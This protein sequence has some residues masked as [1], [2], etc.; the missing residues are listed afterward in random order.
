MLAEREAWKMAE[1][2]DK[3]DLVV[4]NPSLVI[5]PG[6]NPN[7]TSESYSIFKQIG[8]GDFKFGAPDYRIGCVDVR[9]LAEAHFQAGFLPEAK[10]RYIISSDN[11]SFGSVA[12]MLKS[13]FPNYPIG[14]GKIPKWLIWLIA[15]SIGM[16]RKEVKLN[17]GYPWKADNSKSVKELQMHYRPVHESAAE[18]F[19]YLIKNGQIRQR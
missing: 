10:G 18:F 1:Q 8:N 12:K 3:W 13:K 16:T 11:S 14:V 19:D 7:A 6:I 9:D 2:Q 5:G 17:I 4:I 15:P